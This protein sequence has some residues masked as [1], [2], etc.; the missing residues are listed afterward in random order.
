M[1]GASNPNGT[2]SEGNDPSHQFL[3]RSSLD[4]AH[5]LEWDAML[6][7]IS[8]LPNPLVPAY[9][10]LDMRLGWNLSKRWEIALVAQNLLDSQHPEFGASTNRS[11]IERSFFIKSTWKF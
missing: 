3:L 8:A 4:L 6:R 2:A 11:E 9:T 5:N 1:P 10:S 7:H